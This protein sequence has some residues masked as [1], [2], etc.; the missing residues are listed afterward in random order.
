[1]ELNIYRNHS[2]IETVRIDE[3]TRLVQRF[4]G[5]NYIRAEVTKHSPLSVTIGDYIVHK[6]IKFIV[7]TL[8]TVEKVAT[9]YFRYSIV[10]ESE[11]YDLSKVQFLLSGES[12]FNLVSDVETLVDLIVTN[13]NRVYGSGIWSRGTCNQTN[14]DEK[15]LHFQGESCRQVIQRVCTEFGCEVYFLRKEIN[16]ADKMG[17]ATGLTF[18]YKAG[19]RGIS[20]KTESDKNIVTRL[21]VLG[22]EKNLGSSYGSTRL[23][24]TA[25]KNLLTNPGFETG[26]FTGW[27]QWGTPS[28]RTVSAFSNP[29]IMPDGS[30]VPVGT[31]AYQ[32]DG[33]GAN[34]G[35]YQTVTVEPGTSYSLSCYVYRM[36]D[37][38]VLSPTVRMMTQADGVYQY[39]YPAGYSAWERLEL[40][41]TTGAAQTT[42]TVWIGGEGEAWFDAVQIERRDCVTPYVSGTVY[43]LEKNV[44]EYGQLEHTLVLDD[45]FPSRTCTISAVDGSNVLKFTDSSMDFDVNSYLMSGVTAKVNFTSGDL[46]GYTFEVES[47]D[48]GTKEFTIL[49]Y[50]LRNGDALPSASL[51]PA[52]G[53]TFVLVDIELPTSYIEEAEDTLLSRGVAYIDENC[54]PR[55]SYE[56]TPDPRYFRTNNINLSIGDQ[57]TISD[58]D[59]STSVSVRVVELT[60]QLIDPYKVELKLS[61]YQEGRLSQRLYDT[62]ESLR[63]K[64][65]VDRAGDIPRAQLNKMASSELRNII[66]DPSGYI[67]VA[68]LTADN[69]QTGKL[70]AISGNSYFDLDNDLLVIAGGELQ[71]AGTTINS[72]E[73]G[74]DVTVNN[75]AADIVNLPRL[76][77]GAGLYCTSQYLGYWDG[78]E[79]DVYISSGGLFQFKGDSDNYVQ[80]DGSTL[81]VKGAITIQSGSGISNLSDAG[82]LATGDD[83]DDVGDGST[84]K[85]TTENEKTGAGRAYSGLDSSNRLVTAVL[86]GTNIGTPGGSGL[87]LGGDYMGYYSGSQWQSF[88]KSDGTFTFRGDASNYVSWNGSTLTVRGALYA[89]DITS[90]GTITGNTIQTASSG[91]RVVLDRSDNTLKMYDS[92]GDMLIDIDDQVQGATQT[93][94]VIGSTSGA[95]ILLKDVLEGD[96]ATTYTQIFDGQ[97]WATFN[98]N[99]IVMMA[100]LTG[101]N[102]GTNFLALNS[103]GVSSDLFVGKVSTAEKFKVTSA[104]VVTAASYVDAAGGFKD[105]GTAGVDGTFTD[106]DG[107]TITVS[108]GI[109]TDLGT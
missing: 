34:Q 86:P 25:T 26:D 41:V 29:L 57:I 102:T 45:V 44:E 82:S 90:G 43:Y 79:W 93:G 95:L 37:P 49:E 78:S 52:V 89:D 39:A 21:Y 4:F 69:I 94:M 81:N 2:V 56:L 14:T 68:L 75:R 50:D 47:Y 9:N 55:V 8:P 48:N 66:I 88:I 38:S 84:Y 53:D 35:S 65:V 54:V 99:H 74:A 106:N 72:V 61:D 77:S 80:W 73:D 22:A 7:N 19:L 91:Q 33:T 28:T 98:S 46:A 97:V 36:H 15:L 5:E 3:Q 23:K 103:S 10:F 63:K 17:I 85:R 101:G 51:K 12:D 20:R 62:A 32:H 64:A 104:G 13:M 59:L 24:P 109:I 60:K 83:L 70:E 107:N 71:I 18:Q 11:Y 58:S 6:G 30:A 92:S 108:G 67:R 16:V 96:T 42:L 31:Y 87:Y 40:T 27:S 105:N 76:L 100:E 1:M